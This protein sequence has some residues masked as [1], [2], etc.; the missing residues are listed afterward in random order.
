MLS[1]Q[2]QKFTHIKYYQ[3]HLC[4]APL[5]Y[6]RVWLYIF[7]KVK[8]S[9]KTP[10]SNYH[11]KIPQPKLTRI[12]RNWTALNLRL[13]LSFEN[14]TYSVRKTV[15]TAMNLA[16]LAHSQVHPYYQIQA[17]LR[18]A[19]LTSVSIQLA[20]RAQWLMSI[21]NPWS[22]ILPK[23]WFFRHF[24]AIIISKTNNHVFKSNVS[25][26]QLARALI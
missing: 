21:G 11:I 14:A 1:D 9:L 7:K 12:A 6:F 16:A 19:L 8:Q 25:M 2:K 3:L 20:Y 5:C 24:T 17:A 23:I 22:L 10:Y 13:S 26:A 18:P 4:L 15:P